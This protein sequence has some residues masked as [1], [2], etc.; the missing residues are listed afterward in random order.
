MTLSREIA[1]AVD[2]LPEGAALPCRVD[3]ESGP[4]RLGLELVACG[5]VGLAFNTL[6]FAATGG[7]DRGPDDLRA[8]GDRLAGRLT[9]LMEPLV[10]LE[11]DHLAGEAK[12]RSKAPTARE[13]L[14]S[15][16]EIRLGRAGTLRLRRIAFDGTTRARRAVPCQMTREVLERLADDLAASAA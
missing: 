8:W 5:P 3:V 4:N 15:F 16:Y 6:D 11:V 14:R 9:Y 13:D 2:R 12:L 10:L 1:V 7:A